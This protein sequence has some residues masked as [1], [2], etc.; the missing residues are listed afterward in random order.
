M[1][2]TASLL[3]RT[4]GSSLPN[5]FYN[6]LYWAV[7]PFII[8]VVDTLTRGLY[9]R[10]RASNSAT[11]RARRAPCQLRERYFQ[12]HQDTPFGEIDRLK[13]VPFIVVWREPS[14]LFTVTSYS[15]LWAPKLRIDKA[16]GMTDATER[17][18]RRVARHARACSVPS[19]LI[20]S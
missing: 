18:S 16:H 15:N 17:E 5:Y 6:F 8:C 1:R 19:C 13:I 7:A 12:V 20:H 2:D 4:V 9:Y 11:R 14:L 10:S 3:P